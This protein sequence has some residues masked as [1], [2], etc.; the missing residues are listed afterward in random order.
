M[1]KE[2]KARIKINKLLEEAGWHFFDSEEGRANIVLENKTKLTQTELDEFGEDFEKT[3]NGF[4][5]YLLLDDK[6]FPFIVLEAKKEEI[7]PLFAKE[8]ARKYAQSQN[9][10]FV[11]LSNGN[12]HYFWDLQRGNPNIIATFPK[13]ETVIGYTE[14][15]PNAEALIN[16][17]VK[18]DYIVKTQKPDYASD[19]RYI[20]ESQRSAFIEENKLRFL[21]KY[22]VRAIERIQEEVKAGKDRFLFE[23]ATGTGKTL[24]SAAVIKLFLRTGNARRVLFLVDRLELE[25]QAD[26]AFKE[27][28][29]TD[30]KCSIYKENRDD[31]RQAEIVVST[32]QSFLFKNKYKRIFTPTDFDLVISDEAHRS[33]GGNS[34]AV[35]EYFIGY[36][37]GLTATPKDYLKKINA[38]AL[39]E[40]DPRELERRMLLDTYTTFGCEDGKPTFQYSLL[41]GVKD[42]YLVNPCVVDARTEITTQLLSDEGYT[43][44]ITD[45]EGEE[46]S[47][48]F[49]QRDFEKKLFSENTN[50]IFCKTFLENAYRDPISGEIG[51]SI[52]FCVSQNHAA[53]ITQILNEFADKMFPGKYQSDFAMQVTSWI[54]D[55]QQLT[56]NFTNNRLGGKGNFHDLYQT[57][58]TRVCVTVGMMTTGYDCPDILNVCLMR[59]IFSPTDFIQIKGRGTRKYNFANKE[60]L[61]DKSLIDNIPKENLQKSRFKLFDFFANCEFFE[62]KFNYDEVLKL[63]PKGTSTEGGGGGGY[64]VDEY[65]STKHDP[66]K[67]FTVN[68]IG[69]EG[70]KIDRM[71]F[72]KFED[73]VKEDDKIKELVQQKDFDAIE[74]YIISQIFDKPEEYYNISKLRNAIKI[75]RRL[76]LRE[77]IEKIF[78]FIPYFKSK[79]ELLDDEFEKFDSRYLPPEEYFTFAKDYFKSYI[80]DSE[81][82]DII[83]NKKYA[84]LNTNPNGD[85]FRKLPPELRFAIP[86]YIKDNVSLN[87]FVP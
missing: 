40:K 5:D 57:S 75:D 48:T 2:A 80:T 60:V 1:S 77:I 79:D 83:E 21:R 6:G 23:M 26:K 65:D 66:L 33:I 67:T 35:F 45:D 30:Y 71:Y 53:K 41:H 81:F 36:K 14:F 31:W 12:L 55:A 69:V 78:G 72:E 85:V 18:E 7:N 15:K 17:T 43:V 13:P 47:T 46:T 27:Y 16:E 42:G 61:K 11:I 37:L 76:S 32:V 34:R 22:Q 51:K 82:R 84:L 52:V 44:E 19:P 25:D 70:M 39:S 50:R 24:T 68:E 4:I 3:K 20:D 74:Q 59:P 56:I 64:V 8:Q 38:G 73:K 87:K 62:E 58:K 9:C 29:R 86:E 28:L 54:P 10:R 49:S 63:P